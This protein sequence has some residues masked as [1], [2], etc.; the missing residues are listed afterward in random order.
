MRPAVHHDGQKAG[1]GSLHGRLDHP[2]ASCERAANRRDVMLDCVLLVVR[3]SRP[4]EGGS[5]IREV[6]TCKI[7]KCCRLRRHCSIV[8]RVP[9]VMDSVEAVDHWFGSPGSK[10]CHTQV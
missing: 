1:S 6:A 10:D 8:H 3:A 9:Y 4:P 2:S 7:F 5:D